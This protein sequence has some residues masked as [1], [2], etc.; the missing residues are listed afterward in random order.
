MGTQ[1]PLLPVLIRR[2][3]PAV[4]LS[5]TTSCRSTVSLA[6]RA[7]VKS[8]ELRLN[9]QSYK[10]ATSFTATTGVSEELN[11]DDSITENTFLKRGVMLQA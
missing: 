11:S 6:S 2:G 8:V 3:G 9:G 4:S 10:E 5:M 7:S 1:S